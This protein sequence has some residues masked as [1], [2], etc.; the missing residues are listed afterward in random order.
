MVNDKASCNISCTHCYL[1]FTG[2]RSPQETLDLA[3][4]ERGRELFDKLERK[5]M[6][7]FHGDLQGNSSYNK[8]YRLVALA[9]GLSHFGRKKNLAEV[10]KVIAGLGN[11][12][13]TK[14]D[15]DKLSFGHDSNYNAI[16]C[17]LGLALTGL[18]KEKPNFFYTS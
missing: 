14:F 8:E 13:S 11:R 15:R 9:L 4:D 6:N 5:L 10:R 3:G 12:P 17:S 2:N 16:I 18:E 1:P 7:E